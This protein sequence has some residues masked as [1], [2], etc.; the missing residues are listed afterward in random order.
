MPESSTYYILAQLISFSSASLR[1]MIGFLFLSSIYLIVEWAN[2]KE[3]TLSIYWFCWGMI[4]SALATI[5]TQLELNIITFE[6]S[7]ID[8]G[9]KLA[10]TILFHQVWITIC[11]S[12]VKVKR[13]RKAILIIGLIIC[14]YLIL[15]SAPFSR[16]DK[17]LIN[18][19]IL[20]PIN[21]CISFFPILLIQAK[22]QNTF[23]RLTNIFL[24]L[25]LFSL[26]VTIFIHF[27]WLT[28]QIL[29]LPKDGEFYPYVT[30]NNWFLAIFV[31]L[32]LGNVYFQYWLKNSKGHIFV[33]WNYL[34]TI[35][36]LLILW[37]N[38]NIFDTLAL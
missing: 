32:Y 25:F 16:S 19:L 23:E 26:P 21:L 14:W 10:S 36:A 8:S 28:P 12:F 2:K 15:Q 17:H 33:V 24:K 3:P 13:F 22:N 30:L 38:T 35:T 20:L 11:Y 18:A 5:T 27:Y 7:F 34:F 37:F 4:C 9:W 1:L 31:I 6:N 29:S